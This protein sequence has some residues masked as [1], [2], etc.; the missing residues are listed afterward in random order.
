MVFQDYYQDYYA[1]L[2]EN[3]YLYSLT[4]L[5]IFYLLSKL[6]VIISTKFILRITKK[7]KTEVD[8][9]IVKKTN[10]PIS[11]I[12]LFIGIRLALLPLGIK[13]TVLDIFENVLA[14][15]IVIIIT[16]TVIRILDIIIDN[17]GRKLAEKTKSPIDEELLPLFHKFSRIFISI[18]GLLFIL[19]VWDIQ[20]GPLLTSLGIAGVAIAFALQNTLGN[21]FGGISLILDKSIK[22]GDVIKL[23]DQ[24][25]G[26]IADVGL[27]STKIKTLNNE[28]VTVPNGKLADSKI[29]NF[30]QPD[31]TLKISIDFGVEYDSDLDK[32][33][34]VIVATLKSV[35]SILK[36]PE[37]KII[38]IEMGDFA[39][40]LKAVFWVS[41]FDN[42]I[43]TKAI[44]TEEIYKA[45]GKAKIG[46]PFPTRTIY[47]MNNKRNKK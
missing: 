45:L 34:K 17:W 39:L 11:L 42:S 8:D 12:L 30:L 3:H 25:L 19:V 18:V 46:I 1:Y 29:L 32:V 35:K 36:V 26:T 33:R 20:I 24:T 21:I 15:A 31:P 47:I 23:D 22:V 16:F 9:L 28:L 5:V 14:S 38:L 40:K 4:I 13:K 2:I 41:S 37:P 44:A 6:V 10:K 43:E 7:T 27:R